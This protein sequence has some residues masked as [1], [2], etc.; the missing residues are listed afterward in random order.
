M[1]KTRIVFK[2]GNSLLHLFSV[3]FIVKKFFLF[4]RLYLL[5]E[6]LAI[7]RSPANGAYTT[8]DWTEYQPHFT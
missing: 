3:T 8:V 1:D 2:Y 5:V 6:S 7:L 4:S